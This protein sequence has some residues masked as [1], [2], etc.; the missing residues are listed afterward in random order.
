MPLSLFDVRNMFKTNPQF[1][2]FVKA[3][4]EPFL[5]LHTEKF[6]YILKKTFPE[7]SD[8]WINSSLS[9]AIYK[10]KIAL[11]GGTLIKYDYNWCRFLFNFKTLELL[12]KLTP[13]T[14]C[15]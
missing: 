1:N 15:F 3:K 7:V 9:G 2:L 11:Y 8:H 13:K 6:I 4:L 14:V 5:N 10:T 12:N